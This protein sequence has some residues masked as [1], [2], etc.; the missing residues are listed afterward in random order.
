MKRMDLRGFI[1]TLLNHWIAW[2]TGG[3]SILFVALGFIK[4][5]KFKFLKKPNVQRKIFWSMALFFFFIASVSVWTSEHQK[6]LS[7]SN[8]LSK[9]EVESS[10]NITGSI[11]RVL[12]GK[13]RLAEKRLSVDITA[14][15]RNTG[16]P[17]I[18]EG[19]L[20]K[21]ILMNGQIIPGESFYRYTGHEIQYGSGIIE[22]I[23]DS[24]LLD[25]KASQPIPSGGMVR[26][27]LFFFID[28]DVDSISTP[29]TT[30]ELTIYDIK[31]KQIIIK[32]TPT[33]GNAEPI[34]IYPGLETPNL[35]N[36][37]KP[38]PLGVSN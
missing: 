27:R 5:K 29:G 6:V 32:A 30:F 11:D 24:D 28:T 31:G 20:L 25:R 36:I 9:L 34:K 7:L 4:H 8:K 14:S 1:L 17:S 38:K 21:V 22:K 12:I 10:P 26:G 3:A 16:A 33:F 15:L 13:E 23:S 19:F 35:K 37:P 18:A 2:M